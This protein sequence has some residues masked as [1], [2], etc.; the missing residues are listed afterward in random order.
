V[1]Y[2]LDEIVRMVRFDG[3]QITAAGEREVRKALRRTLRRN[4]KITIF[5][6]TGRA[7]S[8]IVAQALAAGYEVTALVR[9]PSRL[10][11]THPHLIVVQGDAI[12]LIAVERAVQGADDCISALA[13]PA[14]NKTNNNILSLATQNIIDAMEKHSI[15]RLIITSSSAIPQ[16]GDKA[17]IRFRLLRMIVK[18]LVPENYADSLRT[19]EKVQASD[20]DWTIVRMG[21]AAYSTPTGIKAGYIHK[22]TGIRITRDDAAAFIINELSEKKYIH[23]APVIWSR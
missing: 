23:Q 8:A 15:K 11:I 13:G 3:W 12:D 22:E 2:D 1:Y 4:M 19:I 16:P 20:T 5:G 6:A 7:G 10:N 21:R 9:N 18:L 14:S 17:N